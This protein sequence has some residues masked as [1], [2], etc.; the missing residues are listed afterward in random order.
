MNEKDL[1]EME[2][3]DCKS[4]NFGNKYTRTIGGWVFSNFAGRM[5]FIPEPAS[6]VKTEPVEKTRKPKAEK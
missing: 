4:D 1:L 5:V 6:V 2:F 3:G